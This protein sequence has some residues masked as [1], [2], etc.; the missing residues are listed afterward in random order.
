M[1]RRGLDAPYGGPDSAR[2]RTIHRALT[3]FSAWFKVSAGLAS[4]ARPEGTGRILVAATRPFESALGLLL[5]LT[6][7]AS[8]SGWPGVRAGLMALGIAFL[9]TA[10]ASRRLGGLTG[11]VLGAVVEVGEMVYLLNLS[12]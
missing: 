1:R 3:L 5:V 7:G 9:F 2:P 12:Y 8:L 6:I 4:Y 10:L 11:D